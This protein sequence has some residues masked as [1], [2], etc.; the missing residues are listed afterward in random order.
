[1][2]KG[3]TGVY[4]AEEH[5]TMAKRLLEPSTNRSRHAV[6]RALT[7]R[8]ANEIRQCYATGLVT[9]TELAAEYGVSNTTIS[10]LVRGL[11]Y[12]EIGDAA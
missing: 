4:D 7:S 1:M 11:S 12:A 9:I 3:F 10:N 6:N 5:R 8:Q 2:V